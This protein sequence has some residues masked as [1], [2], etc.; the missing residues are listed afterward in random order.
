MVPPPNV[1]KSPLCEKHPQEVLNL[2]CQNC[3]ML[4]CI[5][6]VLVTHRSH[7]YNL[8]DDVIEDERKELKEVTLKELETIL[9]STKEAIVTVEQLQSKVKLNNDASV[10][11]LTDAIQKIIDMLS[12]RKK[13]LLQE[14]QQMTQNDLCPLQKQHGDL[15]TLKQ[16]IE[17]CR[18]FTIDTLENGTNSEVMS[19]K[20]QMLERTKMLKELHNGSSL[21][22]VSTPSSVPFFQLDSITIMQIGNFVDLNHSS[23]VETQKHAY[24]SEKV[25]F[26]VIMKDTKGQQ[27]INA[28][29]LITAKVKTGDSNVNQVI[30]IDELGNGEY[31]LSFVPQNSGKYIVHVQIKGYHIANSPYHFNILSLM[32]VSAPQNTDC[33]HVYRKTEN[34][35]DLSQGVQVGTTCKLQAKPKR[36][37]QL[38]ST[39]VFDK[40]SVEAVHKAIRSNEAVTQEA[41]SVGHADMQQYLP[42]SIRNTQSSVPINQWAQTSSNTTVMR[43][44]P[45][46]NTTAMPILLPSSSC[47]PVGS[48][49]NINPY[50]KQ[51]Y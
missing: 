27:I 33:K 13:A 43:A 10:A 29:N 6:C 38:Q 5:Y 36:N 17:Q 2:Y 14:T 15:T 1:K 24:K 30:L 42:P 40:E 18:D 32:S 3:E 19:A 41:G 4:V 16:K 21:S 39:R 9:K 50:Y 45:S 35:R 46:F 34:I 31:S 25:T 37:V 49:R 23:I 20:K 7:D 28:K 22:P 26:K 12:E 44:P 48:Q 11:M 51:K 47:Q 8:V